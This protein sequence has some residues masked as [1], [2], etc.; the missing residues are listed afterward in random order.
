LRIDSI[1]LRGFRNLRQAIA[2]EEMAD[3]NV[4]HGENNVGKSNLVDAIELAFALLGDL[5]MHQWP[6]R[7]ME[8]LLGLR[9]V[10]VLPVEA[11]EGTMELTLRVKLDPAEGEHIAETTGAQTLR[12]GGSVELELILARSAG[13]FRWHSVVTPSY[14][15][16]T[17][18]VVARTIKRGPPPYKSEDACAFL[19]M[20]SLRSAYGGPTG[21]DVVSQ[22]LLTT[23]LDAH[24]A[25]D[26]REHKLWQR[27]S[28][29]V[30]AGLRDS[31]GEGQLVPKYDPRSERVTLELHSPSGAIPV[32]R[33]GGGVQRV[34]AMA[35]SLLASK[36]QI[37]AI[38]E[39]EADLH[40]SL[41]L[42]LR[43]IFK[44]IIADELG[45]KQLLLV[46]HSPVFVATSHGYAVRNS[47][48]GPR[49]ERSSSAKP[50]V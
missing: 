17:D 16:A 11:P 42:R 44:R 50:H 40:H 19:S 23:L 47:P 12:S 6:D 35:G 5:A 14:G 20:P 34:I 43:D 31:M 37:V 27:F 41:Q 26:A 28:D 8:K 32:E 7:Q 33:L 9:P 24:D 38:E 3:I 4:I 22:A 1:R 18:A 29:V 30:V 13:A 45:P 46:S 48:Q 21:R 2:L 10:D 15:R 39:P 25:R 36:A 49:I